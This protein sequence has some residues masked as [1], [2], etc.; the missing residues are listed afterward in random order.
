[1]NLTKLFT[2]PAPAAPVSISEQLEAFIKRVRKAGR[3]RRKLRALLERE[4]ANLR[5]KH[6]LNSVAYYLTLYRGALKKRLG[7]DHDAIPLLLSAPAAQRFGVKSVGLTA[8]EV[9]T[10]KNADRRRVAGYQHSRLPIKDPGRLIQKAIALVKNPGIYDAGP[11]IRRPR[12]DNLCAGL[13]LLTGRR[14]IELVSGSFKKHGKH[15]VLFGGQRKTRQ[16]EGT[17][18][19]A[20]PIHVLAPPALILEATTSLRSLAIP[21]GIVT[22]IGESVR[23]LFPGFKARDLRAVYARLSYHAFAPEGMADLAW[24]AQEL[25][26]KSVLEEATPSTRRSAQIA[27]TLTASY[28]QRFYVPGLRGHRLRLPV[29]R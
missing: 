4:V 28:Y 26:H 16:A 29:S 1:M 8:N 6:T 24:F 13:L 20:Y 18:Q 17:R 14:S 19:S 15:T 2:A 9:V 10:R 25:G 3:D 23:R 11:L 7:P 27:D 21:E 12:L 5:A 22:R